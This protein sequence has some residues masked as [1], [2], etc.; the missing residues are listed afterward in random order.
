MRGEKTGD[1]L[2][3]KNPAAREGGLAIILVCERR[4][5]LKAEKRKKQ[6][7][8]RVTEREVFC[9]QVLVRHE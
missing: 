7:K 3:G 5:E 1:S 6:E 2:G 8:E 9:A 4:K